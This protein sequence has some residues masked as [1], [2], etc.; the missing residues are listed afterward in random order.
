M[1]SSLSHSLS[2]NLRE[3]SNT[4]QLQPTSI[5]ICMYISTPS[6]KSLNICGNNNIT[7]LHTHNLSICCFLMKLFPSIMKHFNTNRP[8]TYTRCSMCSTLSFSENIA[9][10][11]IL[12]PY[13]SCTSWC[14]LQLDLS[15]FQFCSDILSFSQKISNFLASLKI[16]S[17]IPYPCSLFEFSRILIR[18]VLCWFLNFFPCHLLLQFRNI[19]TVNPR[20]LNL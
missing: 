19:L 8:F 11:P 14:Y 16:L 2:L 18:L 1:S 5:Y 13:Y 15:T 12:H 6:Y 9:I 20:C 10:M 3:R 4:N 7:T 17:L